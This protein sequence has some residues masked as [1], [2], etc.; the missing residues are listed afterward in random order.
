MLAISRVIVFARDL[1]RLAVFYGDVLGLQPL[2]TT[3]SGW[4]EF[5]AGGCRIA[6][7]REAARRKPRVRPRSSF[8]AR[9]WPAFVRRS[10][11]G[12]Q[13]SAR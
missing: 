2:A 7:H 10:T 9:T 4:R 8:I 5:D 6:L 11:R 3:E 13:S 1:K 12:E